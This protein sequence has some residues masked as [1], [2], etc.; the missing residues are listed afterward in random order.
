MEKKI[1]HE[2]QKMQREQA[3]AMA[4]KA[5]SDKA[6]KGGKGH[7][8]KRM[9]SVSK[10][11]MKNNLMDDEEANDVPV[12]MKDLVALNDMKTNK[13]DTEVLMRQIDIQH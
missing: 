6:G 12:G 13:F 11:T 3:A 5:E 2:K 7:F 4:E 8:H 1:K 9:K 10:P